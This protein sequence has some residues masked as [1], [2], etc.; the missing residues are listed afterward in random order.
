M[1]EQRA[2]NIHVHDGITEDAFVAMREG[3]DAQL[4]MPAS[5]LPSVQI[6]MRAGK[7][8]PPA[9]NGQRSSIIPLNAL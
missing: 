2:H 3:R 5:I 6:N 4:G 9:E 7:M 1:A 8:P